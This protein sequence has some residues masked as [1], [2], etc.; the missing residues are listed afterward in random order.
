MRILLADDH[1][2]FR[3]GLAGLLR[4]WDMEVV[5]QASDGLEALEQAR[6]LRPDIILMDVRM[7]RSNGLEATRLIKTEMPDIRIIMLTVSDDEEDLF[8]AIKSGAQG[9]L[10]KDVPEEEF[11]QILTSIESGDAPLS[12]G[13]AVRILEEFSRLAK[14]HS[15][16]KAEG[17]GLT[18]R[19]HEVLDM[20]ASGATNR[21]IGA[22]LYISE[23]TVN[24]HIKNILSKL[25]LKN[26]GQA[27][28]YA[29]RTGLVNLP[30]IDKA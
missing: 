14:E 10:L 28:A 16:S 20:V 29:I 22:G 26:R 18:E 11:R 25:H 30:P 9:Y 21:E 19:E 24:Y 13:L 23:N 27:I 3:A 17:D 1:A 7:P 8:E 12:R 6:K 15:V 5:G 2:L 4:A